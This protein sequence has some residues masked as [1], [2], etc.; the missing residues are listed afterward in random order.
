MYLGLLDTTYLFSYAFFMFASGFIAERSDLRYFLSFGML[1]SG[2]MTYLFGFAYSAGIHSIWYLIFIQIICGMFQTTGWPGVVTVV[3][4]WFGKGR[5]GL[6]FGIWNSHT[7][8]GNILGSLIAG[9][10]VLDNWGLSFVI[11]GAVIGT[12]GFLL[13]L[14]MPPTPDSVGLDNP[15]DVPEPE[16]GTSS[17]STVMRRSSRSIEDTETEE[18]APLIQASNNPSG[19]GATS[20]I[21]ADASHQYSEQITDQPIAP[22]EEQAITMWN[23]LKIPGVV[24]FSLSLFFSKLVSYTF[25]YWLPNYIN[26][27]SHVDAEESAILSTLFDIGGIMGG[28]IAGVASDYSG[29]SAVTCAIMLIM[30]IPSMFVYERLV[31]SWCP[32]AQSGGIPIHNICFTS[33]IIVLVVAG[34]LVNGPYSLITTAVSAELGT[35]K[36]LRGS[37][38]A[39]A[40]VTAI[41]D[42]TGS[43]GAALGPL[44]AGWLSGDGNWD[45][46]FMMLML[47]DVIALLLLARLIK[48]ELQ[49]WMANRRRERFRRLVEEDNNVQA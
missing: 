22:G 7:S 27:T 5:R 6:I 19:S 8:L 49:R 38:K 3:A 12:V 16:E 1:M 2:V 29:M 24:E 26:S 4:N 18:N 13:F 43:I 20:P 23:A 33:N 9:A 42:G 48:G 10:F 34:I 30:A 36:S 11:P 47:A 15:Q 31:S 46:V 14:F 21:M 25:L 37:S 35:H 45:N 17:K 28:I 32:I 40:T 44:M 41:I 39:L